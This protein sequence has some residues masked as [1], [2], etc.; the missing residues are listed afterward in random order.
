[1]SSWGDFTL[2]ELASPEE[3]YRPWLRDVSP[4]AYTVDDWILRLNGCWIPFHGYLYMRTENPKRPEDWGLPDWLK[5]EVRQRDRAVFGGCPLCK[6]SRLQLQVHHLHYRSYGRESIWDL[7][8]LCDDCH[9][10]IHYNPQY[11]GSDTEIGH[12]LEWKAKAPDEQEKQRSH[13]KIVVAEWK[14][15]MAL[16]RRLDRWFAKTTK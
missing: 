15:D 7:L 14:A 3:P 5:I 4:E 2:D 10:S 12:A 16:D 11:T 8:G 13:G 9:H 6:N 1:M